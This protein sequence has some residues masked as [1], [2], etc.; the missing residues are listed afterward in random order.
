MTN[1]E[2]ASLLWQMAGLIGVESLIVVVKVGLT[3]R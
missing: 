1:S 2:D 3:D